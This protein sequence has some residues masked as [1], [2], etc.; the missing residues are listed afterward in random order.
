MAQEFYPQ[1][2][3]EIINKGLRWKDNL[4]GTEGRETLHSNYVPDNISEINDNII[5]EV[6]ACEHC[7]RNYKIIKP[8]LKL[9]KQLG[10]PVPKMCPN[11]RHNE[12]MNLRNSFHLWNRQCMCTQ[13]THNHSGRCKNT[14]ETS[15]N[16]EKLEIV[17]CD[18]CY[19]KEI[20]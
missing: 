2:K 14:I 13:P 12:R 11:C 15:F 17:Y 10:L 19:N 16:P 7:K 18:I 9:L 20:Y 6:L 8:E 5:K 1:K 3:E 4:P